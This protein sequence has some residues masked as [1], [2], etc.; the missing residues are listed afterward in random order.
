MEALCKLGL[1]APP[2]LFSS[3]SQIFRINDQHLI[4]FIYLPIIRSLAPYSLSSTLFT[5][6]K[7]HQ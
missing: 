4:A 7:E 2:F 3:Y 5:Y 6:R 1:E